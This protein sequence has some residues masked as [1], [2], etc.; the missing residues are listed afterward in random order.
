MNI[1]WRTRT[2][3]QLTHAELYALLKLRVDVFVVEQRCPYPEIDGQDEEA[4]HVLGHADGVLVAYARIL[5]PHA[6]GA[7]HIGR[8]VVHGDHRGKG[9]GVQVMN[10]A[11]RSLRNTYGNVAVVVSAQAHLQRFY[12]DL[13][14]ERIS[15][16]YDWDGIPHID[17]RLNAAG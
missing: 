17:M 10:E 6:D 1:G 12:E 16:E 8:V 13:G 2:F 15:P 7:P 4:M 9:L 11:L 14:F 5:P 3:T